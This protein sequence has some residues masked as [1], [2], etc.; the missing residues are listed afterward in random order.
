MQGFCHVSCKRLSLV[1]ILILTGM[2][3]AGCAYHL[4]PK[5]L[6]TE[7]VVDRISAKPEKVEV[8]PVPEKLPRSRLYQD[9]I[10][11]LKQVIAEKDEL[12][13]SLNARGLDQ[14]QV[15][16]ETA[17]E[18]SRTKSKLHRLATQPEAASKIAEI[19]VAMGALKQIVLD[20]S[21]IALQFLAQRLLDTATVAYGQKDYSSAMSHAAQSGELIDMIANPSRKTLESQHITLI[22]RTPVT[23]FTTHASDLRAGPSGQSKV[24][25][26]LV[27]NTALTATAYHSDWLRVRTED[28]RFGWIQNSQVD[29]RISS[30][31]S[32][33]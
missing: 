29:I 17:S 10:S 16:K 7:P 19:E 30:P 12:I 6:A 1:L 4:Q 21:D 13:R 22:F 9:E 24:R 25:S 32:G 2:G 27:K 15:L 5:S 14:A 23:L 26:L 3:V 31:I 18:V 20:E 11:R 28:G 8:I 33:E